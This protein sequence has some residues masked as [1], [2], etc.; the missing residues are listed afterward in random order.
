M[1]QYCMILTFPKSVV[2]GLETTHRLNWSQKRQLYSIQESGYIFQIS[3]NLCQLWCNASQTRGH[4]C[5]TWFQLFFRLHR[6]QRLR[7]GAAV[8]LDAVPPALP[9][10]ESYYSAGYCKYFVWTS[11]S[12]W[13]TAEREISY[14]RYVQ[15]TFDTCHEKFQINTIFVYIWNMLCHIYNIWKIQTYFST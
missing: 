13:A 14:A 3:T 8:N 11:S 5:G 6:D 15:D 12:K 10:H 2:W 1:W 9:K 7:F 4:C